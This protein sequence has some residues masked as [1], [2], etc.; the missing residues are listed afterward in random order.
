MYHLYGMTLIT[1][2]LERNWKGS[3]RKSVILVLKNVHHADKAMDW[4]LEKM[5][6]WKLEGIHEAI[7]GAVANTSVSCETQK[8]FRCPDPKLWFWL[9]FSAFRL[10]AFLCLLKLF[11]ILLKTS[12]SWSEN[13]RMTVGQSITQTCIPSPVLANSKCLR[14]KDKWWYFP[15]YTL[16]WLWTFL[17]WRSDF[18]SNDLYGI[19]LPH[20]CL[21]ALG[22]P[23][24]TVANH[25]LITCCTNNN[26]LIPCC[27]LV[28]FNSS[29]LLHGMSPFSPHTTDTDLSAF[30]LTWVFSAILGK[31]FLHQELPCTLLPEHL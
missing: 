23:T 28:Q 16:L 5:D 7:S 31:N 4:I 29:Q 11:A 2:Y 30:P 22:Y 24:H 18:M 6:S 13:S 14:E 3:K 26:L 9:P 20:L 8:E 15:K 12:L 25:T 1:Q 10:R 19:L 27:L 21:L 17:S